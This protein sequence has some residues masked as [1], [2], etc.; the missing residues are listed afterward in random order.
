[1]ATSKALEDLKAEM[2]V[3][4]ATLLPII[5][6]LEDFNRLN[7]KPETKGIV[8]AFLGEARKR[9]TL[10]ANAQAA[11]DGLVTDEYPSLD[12]RIVK[13]AVYEDLADQK[14]TID[15]ALDK[16]TPAEEADTIT[17]VPGTPVTK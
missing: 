16:F 8:T 12:T 3:A 11:L 9:Q 7:I 6:G 2:T 4:Q 15:A 14:R 13:D 10:L 1:M 17:I 5:E